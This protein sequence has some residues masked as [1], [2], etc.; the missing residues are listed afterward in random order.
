MKAIKKVQRESGLIEHVCEHGIGHPT[1]ES[2]KRISLYYG[3]QVKIWM[4]HG[5]DGCCV[6]DS[7]LTL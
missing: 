2:A 7:K 5:C 3:N 1:L 6:G 4:I